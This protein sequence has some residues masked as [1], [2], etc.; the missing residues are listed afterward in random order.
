V[1]HL[2]CS[3]ESDD[4]VLQADA[5]AAA[6]LEQKRVTYTGNMTPVFLELSA[7]IMLQITYSF[8]PFA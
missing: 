4:Y 8:Q 6:E 5:L 2:A 3:A 7:E 1:T